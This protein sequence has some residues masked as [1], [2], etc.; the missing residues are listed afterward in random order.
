MQPNASTSAQPTPRPQ[1]DFNILRAQIINALLHANGLLQQNN[2][3]L[4]SHLVFSKLV[5][6][7]ALF[8]LQSNLFEPRLYLF[9]LTNPDGTQANLARMDATGTPIELDEVDRAY[10]A[11][12]SSSLGPT[13][14]TAY[15]KMVPVEPLIT[16]P[17]PSSLQ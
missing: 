6:L 5:D 13:V 11:A 1:V 10:I 16:H 17:A 7:T 14:H 12:I 4:Q 9:Q 2:A 15:R 8:S 3:Q